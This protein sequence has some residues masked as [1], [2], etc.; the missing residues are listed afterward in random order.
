M[1]K[2]KMFQEVQGVL[3]VG[4][5]YL[6]V[7]GILNETLYYNQIG[8]D[9][10]RYSNIM[11]VLISPISKIISSIIGLSFF[12]I[13][14]WCVFTLP[15]YLAKK[16]NTNWFKKNI[17][18]EEHLSQKEVESTLLASFLLVLAFA[19]M[20]S[21]VGF[22]I[23]KGWK[24]SKKI[25]QGEIKYNDQLSFMNGDIEKVKIVGTNSAYIFYLTNEN[26]TVRITPINGVL[27][28]ID[29]IKPKN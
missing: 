9:I 25:E 19:L 1:S 22:G 10:L 28:S 13:I 24:M 14:V 4:Y 23:G 6:V 7:M 20:G 27:K 2:V 16:R 11:D 8:V 17:K 12:L 5:I 29:E 18:V 3:S 15:G 21:F 26:K